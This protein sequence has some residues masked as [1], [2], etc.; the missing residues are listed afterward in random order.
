MIKLVP[1]ELSTSW[2]ALRSMGDAVS[3][4]G[5]R[6]RQISSFLVVFGIGCWSGWVIQP[7]LAVSAKESALFALLGGVI[8]LGG[9]LAGFMVTLMLFSGRVDGAGTMTSEQTRLVIDR[10][11]ILL[12]SQAQ[13]LFASVFAA[14]FSV[15]W[16][17]AYAM[18]ADLLS[19]RIV[20]AACFGYLLVAVVRCT[21]IPLQIFE[22]HESLL[23]DSLESVLA[24]ERQQFA[25]GVDKGQLGS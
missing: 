10:V 13:T 18:S 11:K 12:Y 21:L 1:E 7:G 3:G 25:E 20:A 19:Q 6:V 9:L 5:F 15:A 16:L 2:G 14:V 22:L 4:F 17:C 24:R 23:D 8:A